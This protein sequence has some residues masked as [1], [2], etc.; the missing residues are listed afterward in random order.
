MSELIFLFPLFL[1]NNVKKLFR[2]YFEDYL[3][4]VVEFFAEKASL[5]E[6]HIQILV[7]LGRVLCWLD[8]DIIAEIYPHMTVRAS[9]W[10]K[11]LLTWAEKSVCFWWM[12]NELKLELLLPTSFDLYFLI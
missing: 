9:I 6:I 10:V 5:E 11:I 4:L 1:I 7:Y 12:I 2:I 8:D 3:V